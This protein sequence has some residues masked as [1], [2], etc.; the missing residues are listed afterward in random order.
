MGYAAA[1][2][3]IDA[4]W[5]AALRRGDL[6]GPRA[7]TRSTRTRTARTTRWSASAPPRGCSASGRGRSWRPATPR[8]WLL[9][10]LAGWL[11]GLGVLVLSRR[12]CCRRAC[13][14]GRLSRWTSTIRRAA[15]GC[16]APTARSGWRSRW[17]SW[18]ARCRSA[19]VTGMPTRSSAPTRCLG[20]APLVPEIRAASGHRDHADLAGDRGL[21]AR[22]RRRAAVLGVRLAGR[23]GAGAACAGQSGAGRRQARAGFRRRRR[24]RRDRLRAGRRGAAWRRRRSTRWRVAAIRLNAADNGV[25]VD[26]AGGRRRGRRLPLGPDPVRRRLLRGADDR[27]HPA[28]AAAHG[29][30]GR[31]LDRRSRPRLSAARGW[32]HSRASWCRPRWNWRTGRNGGDAVS[33]RFLTPR[34][35]RR[36]CRPV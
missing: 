25:A 17:R 3:R 20:A 2:G 27:P 23:A 18:W 7:S 14:R 4:A 10:A 32:P 21:A 15:C 1:A 35:H 28:V 36:R 30:A 16:S 11:A 26:V 12:W 5:A 6:L 13:W 31:G 34:A 8:P 22:T 24:H 29:G 33:R 9:L 19:V